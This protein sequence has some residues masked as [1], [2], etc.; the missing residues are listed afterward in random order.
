VAAALRAA[1]LE[2]KRDPRYRHPFHWAPF[3]VIGDGY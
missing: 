1:A 2:I 3:V